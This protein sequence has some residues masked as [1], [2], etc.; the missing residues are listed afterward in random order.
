MS[1]VEELVPRTLGDFAPEKRQE[2]VAIEVGLES[3]VARFPSRGSLSRSGRRRRPTSGKPVFAG[4]DFIE[5]SARLDGAGP[6]HQHRRAEAAFESSAPALA[7]P[8]AAL[9]P[10]LPAVLAPGQYLGYQSH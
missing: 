8:R 10:A 2:V 1:E 4:K 5:D 7:T 6:L 9:P 3:F